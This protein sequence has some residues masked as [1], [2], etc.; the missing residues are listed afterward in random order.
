MDQAAY[1]SFE[2]WGIALMGHLH[3]FKQYPSVLEK[4]F[5][6]TGISANADPEA[7]KAQW[8]PMAAWW[9]LTHEIVE[10]VGANTAYQ[11][12]RKIA[13]GAPLPPEV[14]SV[15]GALMGV[16]ISYHMHHRKDGVIMFDPATGTLLDGIG[17]YHC[18]LEEGKTSAKMT[19]DNPYSCDL[20]RGILAGFAARFEA[21]V[22]VSHVD[23]GCRKKGDK[24]CVYL[25]QW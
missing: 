1:A 11:V 4:F 9:Q 19:C 7:L 2:V 25:I 14:D 23:S 3:A 17:H 21:A 18:Q 20:D 12:G 22:S 16:D 8:V 15:A 24:A 13:E 10:E 6:R 5:K